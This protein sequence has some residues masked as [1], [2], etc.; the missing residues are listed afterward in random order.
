MLVVGNYHKRI[1]YK[2]LALT[3]ERIY[4]VFLAS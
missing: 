4:V 2:S 3:K 1:A